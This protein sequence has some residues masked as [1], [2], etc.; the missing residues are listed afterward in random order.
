MLIRV[1]SLSN[2][3]IKEYKKLLHNRQYRQ[4]TNKIILEGP[5]LVREAFKAGFIPEVVFY[6]RDY[7]E[8]SGIEWLTKLPREVK[9]VVLSEAVFKSIAE[10]ETPR[11]VAAILPFSSD[12]RDIPL[13]S[14][15]RL[16]LILDRLQD[17]GNMGTIIRTAAAAGVDQICYSSGSVDPYSPKVLRST[18]GTIFNIS[19]KAVDDLKALIADCREK[20]IRVITT[21]ARSGLQLWNAD[22]KG[23]IAL[24]IGNEADGVSPQLNTASE[25]KVSIPLAGSVDS[26]NA[27]VA[28]GI[29]M[30]EIVR[31]NTTR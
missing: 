1:S 9:Q 29:I 24:I 27:G 26:L 16:I 19:L 8:S 7:F 14:E 5:N 23:P 13:A 30:F 6:T 17:P 10:T 2:P 20:G 22:L 28:A 21:C 12:H 18:A 15:P 25:L 4:K 3:L 31:Q 11:A